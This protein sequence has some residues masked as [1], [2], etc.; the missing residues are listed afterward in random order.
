M[1]VGGVQGGIFLM[2]HSPRRVGFGNISTPGYQ[3]MIM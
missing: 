1:G 3:L 2:S